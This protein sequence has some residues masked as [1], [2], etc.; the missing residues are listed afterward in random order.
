[1]GGIC[2]RCPLGV[3]GECEEL[4][5]LRKSRLDELDRGICRKTGKI[6]ILGINDHAR[7]AEAGF[8]EMWALRFALW[9]KKRGKSTN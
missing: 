5:L 4:E 7:V 1:M 3:M 8:W 6:V 9:K 2:E